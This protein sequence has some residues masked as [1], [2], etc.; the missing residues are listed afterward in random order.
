MFDSIEIHEINENNP[1]TVDEFQHMLPIMIHHYNIVKTVYQEAIAD[2]FMRR[3][4][5][6]SIELPRL[7]KYQT[8]VQH[9]QHTFKTFRK[10]W[11]ETEQYL[12]TLGE[13]IVEK[14]FPK[15]VQ[16]GLKSFFELLQ[17]ASSIIPMYRE[18]LKSYAI[19]M[20]KY[21]EK[22][23]EAALKFIIP[24]SINDKEDRAKEWNTKARHTL[25]TSIHNI[26]TDHERFINSSIK[27]IKEA[28]KTLETFNDDWLR[29]FD[30]AVMHVA[31]S[32]EW[33]NKDRFVPSFDDC[34]DVDEVYHKVVDMCEAA[35]NDVMN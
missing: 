4:K 2:Q 20:M 27:P 9:I 30:R 11:Y 17:Y 15:H 7:V 19:T 28:E 32:S 35:L 24:E 10:E 6:L 23:N 12:Y 13:R 33:L 14:A 25:E 16:E 18:I 29:C 26:I 34:D 21:Y 8:K 1:E 31:F 5:K 3:L 22:T